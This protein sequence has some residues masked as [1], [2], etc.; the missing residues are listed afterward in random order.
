MKKELRIPIGAF[1]PGAIMTIGH[2]I[3]TNAE[4]YWKAVR[5]VPYYVFIE[6]LKMA[7]DV[8]FCKADAL[9]WTSNKK[10][11]SYL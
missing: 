1:T 4:D 8:L 10:P 6:R 11:K 9:Y 7:W 3:G 2:T 5:P